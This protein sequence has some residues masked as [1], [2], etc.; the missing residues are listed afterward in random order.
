[1]G[2]VE[3]F[4]RQAAYF[5]VLSK[6]DKNIEAWE[7]SFS[8]PPQGTL[9]CWDNLAISGCSIESFRDYTGKTWRQ[10]YAAAL[11]HYRSAKGLIGRL[12]AA[13]ALHLPINGSYT[14][15]PT[16]DGVFD[17]L[18]QVEWAFLRKPENLILHFGHND[19]LY[20]V[21]SGG[22]PTDLLASKQ[23]YLDVIEMVL[24]GPKE[25]QHIVLALLPKVSCVANLNPE[26]DLLPNSSY[27]ESY[28]T[29]F[30][31]QSAAIS[32]EDLREMDRQIKELNGAVRML[33]SKA[34]DKRRVTIVDT[35][36]ILDRL[37]YK[38][39]GSKSARIRIKGKTN[40]EDSRAWTG[41]I[42]VRWGMRFLPT[43]WPFR[44]DCPGC[45]PA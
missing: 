17:G 22:K 45:P 39:T 43:K 5:S 30:P 18:T 10:E 42:R 3:D 41:C 37:D 11:Q 6:I 44:W 25:I 36:Q 4:I 2:N 29:E 23:A 32:G 20:S 8:K 9:K 19:G 12:K 24:K 16:G 33:A 1:L 28:H 35:Y 38:N 34:M 31:F 21:G 7:S 26:G 14:L 13:V 40:T 27:F 15:N